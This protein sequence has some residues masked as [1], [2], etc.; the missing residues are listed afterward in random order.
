MSLIMDR[1]ATTRFDDKTWS[2]NMKYRNSINNT[3]CLYNVPRR[4]TYNINPDISIYCIEMNNSKNQIEGIGLIKNYLCLN[5]KHNIHE[6]KNYNRFTYKGKYRITRDEIIEKDERLIEILEMF[7]F[8]GPTHMKRGQGI[9]EV[10]SW[11][12]LD[13]KLNI[14]PEINKIFVY[15]YGERPISIF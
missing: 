1:L 13:K 15:K 8:H 2:E 9:Q 10:P 7:L 14:I 12:S 3:G 6:E 5:K 4:I 11:L